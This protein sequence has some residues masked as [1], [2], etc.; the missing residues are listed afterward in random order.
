MGTIKPN[1][2]DYYE[3]IWLFAALRLSAQ[4]KMPRTM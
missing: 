1:C 3:F 4:P 2:E